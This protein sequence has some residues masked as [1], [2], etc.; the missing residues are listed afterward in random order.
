MK[1]R[2]DAREAGM[3]MI[4]LIIGMAI[5]VMVVVLAV[6]VLVNTLRSQATVTAS[7]KAATQ[8]QNVSDLIDQAVREATAI[9]VSNTRLDVDTPA[10][11][12][13]FAVVGDGV[14]HLASGAAIGAATSS[15]PTLADSVS[16]VGSSP[17]FAASTGGVTYSFR[18]QGADGAVD[19]VSRAD[20]RVTGGSGATCGF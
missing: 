4:E 12:Q 11:C 14:R 1:T 16:Q 2:E 18:L 17:Y 15:W 6:A 8:G 10:G 5:G 20:Q 19:I 3:T 13:A 9:R 7:T